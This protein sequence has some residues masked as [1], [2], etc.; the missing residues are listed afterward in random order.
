MECQTAVD[1]FVFYRGKILNYYEIEDSLGI[2]RNGDQ[3]FIAVIA[4]T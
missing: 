4:I 1:D 3:Y 2:N